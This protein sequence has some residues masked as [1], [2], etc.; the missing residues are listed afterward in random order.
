MKKKFLFS[1]VSAVTILLL[2]FLPLRPPQGKNQNEIQTTD[3]VKKILNQSCYDCHS[4]LTRWPWYSK[5]F[6]STFTYI[7][8]W[9]KVRRNSIFRNGNF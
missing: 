4:D 5:I 8:T 9:K 6:R 2:Q 7:T 3:E 1:I